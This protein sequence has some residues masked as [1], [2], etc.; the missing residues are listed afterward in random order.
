MQISIPE[1]KLQNEITY[2]KIGKDNKLIYCDMEL[3][4][5]RSI[6]RLN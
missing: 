4:L 5:I 1:G 6:E 3:N 2:D